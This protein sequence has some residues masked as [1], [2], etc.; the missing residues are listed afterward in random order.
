[1]EESTRGRISYSSNKASE[2]KV[3]ME[4]ITNP[5]LSHEMIKRV[6]DKLNQLIIQL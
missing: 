6:E 5:F 1:M 4:I 2:M 3:L